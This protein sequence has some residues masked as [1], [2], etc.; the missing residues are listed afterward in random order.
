MKS[1]LIKV[2]ISC[3]VVAVLGTGGFFGYKQ[4]FGKKT[5]VVSTRSYSVAVQKKDL[6]KSIQGTGSIY[7]GSTKDV[8]SSNNGTLSGLTVKVGD[9]V[10]AGQTLFTATSTD[11]TQNVT[12]AENNLTKAK[13]QLTSDTN[14]YN[15]AV[16]QAENKL[17]DVKAT[18]SADE[19][20]A[21]VDSNKV[22]SD[23]T[24]ISDAETQLSSAEADTNKIVSDKMSI[25][26]AETQLSTAETA[27]AKITVTA[28]IGGL[29]TAVNNSDGDSVQSGKAVLT[30]QNM[31][32]LD[33]NVSVDELDINSVSMGKAATITFDAISGKT[34]NGT[35]TS[36]G[37]TGTTSNNVTTYDV[38][39]SIKNPDS[40]IKLG[41]NGTATIIT[42][43]KANALVIP[44]EAL[45]EVNSKKYVRVSTSSQVQNNGTSSSTTSSTASNSKLVEIK[46]GIE[47]TDYIEVTSGVS[48]GDQVIVQLPQSTTTNTRNNNNGFGGMNGMNGG[49]QGGMG[50]FQG[51]SRQGNFSGSKGGN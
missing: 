17:T 29:V 45:V 46:T 43:S 12:Q 18:L 38:V 11:L 47:T 5:V 4:F 30:I 44:A 22:A 31:N 39:V 9:T 2:I 24:A 32:S 15:Q 40:K 50:G 19:S 21:K 14:S 16:T 8:S 3:V 51:G 7:S 49:P 13:L 6:S 1:K 35:V 23:K 20:T 48:E 42:E 26:D 33:V 34:Y 36:I 10:K 41:M 28:P 37:Q 27:L 25:S